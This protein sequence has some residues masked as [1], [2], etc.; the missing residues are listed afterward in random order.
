[1]AVRTLPKSEWQSYFDRVSKDLIGDRAMVEVIGLAFGN[2]T[3]ARCM[4]LIG[5]TYDSKD[6]ILQIALDGLDHLI[7]GPRDIVVNDGAEGLDQV[8]IVDADRQKQI[9]RLV[10]PLRYVHRHTG[11]I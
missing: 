2:R 9:V 1:M 8:E 3:E 6:D 10:R 5:I 11:A 7:R 4:S